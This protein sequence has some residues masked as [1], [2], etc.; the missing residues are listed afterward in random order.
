MSKIEIDSQKAKKISWHHFWLANVI[1]DIGEV[2]PVR[3]I[4]P[5][6]RTSEDS[7]TRRLHKLRDTKKSTDYR[8]NSWCH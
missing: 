5:Q 1:A 6:M 3:G 7:L 8:D 4:R 2:A